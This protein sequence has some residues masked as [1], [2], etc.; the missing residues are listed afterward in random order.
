MRKIFII[1]FLLVFVFCLSANATCKNNKVKKKIIELK[2]DFF[3]KYVPYRLSLN[4]KNTKNVF[5]KSNNIQTLKGMNGLITLIGYEN[6]K[7]YVYKSVKKDTILLD[8]VSIWFKEPPKE[9]YLNNKRVDSKI[10][11]DDIKNGCLYVKLINFNIDISFEIFDVNMI[12]FE[13]DTIKNFVSKGNCLSESNYKILYNNTSNKMPIMF[14]ITLG[15]SEK[16]LL[17]LPLATFFLFKDE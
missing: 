3:Y 17:P 14:N 6:D 9:V 5:F 1:H 4:L 10:T 13:N 16:D 8:S 2:S 15:N 12:Y 11:L 7:I